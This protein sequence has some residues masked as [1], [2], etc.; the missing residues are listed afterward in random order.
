[1]VTVA[2]VTSVFLVVPEGL[3]VACAA[4]LGGGHL[5]MVLL[6]AAVPAG[7]FVGA[8]AIARLRPA[9]RR[10]ALI[11]PLAVLTAAPLVVTW[12]R[13]PALVVVLAWTLAGTGGA[14]HVPALATFVVHTPADVRGRAFGLAESGLQAVQGMALLLAGALTTLAPATAVVAGAGVAGVGATLLLAARWPGE[15]R[16]L[17]QSRPIAVPL[18]AGG[19]TKAA[20]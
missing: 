10:V 17:G 13:P 2:W 16:S 3:A 11:C 18:P 9:H 6:V 1:M 12:S 19:I 7:G 8:L 15:V 5:T 14:L 20:R 4:D